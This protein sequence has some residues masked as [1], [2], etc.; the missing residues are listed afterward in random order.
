ML[1][2]Q[3][4]KFELITWEGGILAFPGLVDR[5]SQRAVHGLSPL[6]GLVAVSWEL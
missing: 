3:K 4:I 1:K 6:C 5:G 2:C